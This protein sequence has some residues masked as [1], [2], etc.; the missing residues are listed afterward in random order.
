MTEQIFL[1]PNSVDWVAAEAGGI[2][3]AARAMVGRASLKPTG[4][5][6]KTTAGRRIGECLEAMAERLTLIDAAKKTA[7]AGRLTGR[8]GAL[9]LMA[10]V[11]IATKASVLWRIVGDDPSDGTPGTDPTPGEIVAY[12]VGVWAD[13]VHDHAKDD[14]LMT[15]VI[16]SRDDVAVQDSPDKQAA[17][18]ALLA[19]AK[20]S[21]LA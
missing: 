19:H 16:L 11:D 8:G 7:G 4:I 13:F 12:R 18:V 14:A 1:A 15:E 21:S 20:K 6:P 3:I 2:E 17:F 9:A 10:M 5:D